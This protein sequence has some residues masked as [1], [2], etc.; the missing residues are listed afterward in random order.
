MAGAIAELAN[1]ALAKDFR[2][3]D[4][5]CARIILVEAAPRLLTPFDPSLSKA[6]R[7]SLD[8]LGVE[9]KLDAMVSECGSEGV[10]AGGEFL[11]SRTIIWAARVMAS[12]AC[13]CLG[14]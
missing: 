3:I 4:P 8:Q 2:S 13:G 9:V 6:A 1:R 10:R 5:R 12:R 7:C 11:G 14:A